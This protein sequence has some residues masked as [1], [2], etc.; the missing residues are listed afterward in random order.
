M[1]IHDLQPHSLSRTFAYHLK[2]DKQNFFLFKVEKTLR[3]LLRVRDT[4][5]D[6]K[7]HGLDL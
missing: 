6:V 2:C 1:S 3:K 7:Q 5:G 4:E